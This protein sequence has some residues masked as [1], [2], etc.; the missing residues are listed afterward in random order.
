MCCAVCVSY[1]QLPPTKLSSSRPK[2]FHFPPKNYHFFASSSVP[3][4]DQL[5]PTLCGHSFVYFIVSPQEHD[6]CKDSIYNEHQ[7]RLSKEEFIQPSKQLSPP[8]H[9]TK[10]RTQKDS[11]HEFPSTGIETVPPGV[12]R[13]NVFFGARG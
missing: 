4:S 10:S 12:W 1:H 2:I 9:S 8:I 3:T 6:P 11:R 13:R 5:C 7:E